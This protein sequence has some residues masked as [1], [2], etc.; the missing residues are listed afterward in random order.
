M[1]N[2]IGL[3]AARVLIA[4]LFVAGALQKWMDPAPA[5]TLLAA[6]GLPAFLVW[7]ALIG[8]GIAAIALFGGIGV[9]PVSVA[10][11][12]YCIATSWFHFLPDDGWQMSIFIKNW[13]IAGG[14]FA[15]AVA[16][17]GRI[18]LR[19]DPSPWA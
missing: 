2:D 16:G 17:S 6:S 11:G 18:A 10:L 15:L 5:A 19:P 12:A 1:R 8:N 7:G 14:C 9:K 4:V 3:L 13:A